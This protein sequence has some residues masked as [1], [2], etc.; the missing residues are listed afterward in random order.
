MTVIS[1]YAD[2]DGKTFYSDCAKRLEQNCK[3]LGLK[4][5]IRQKQYGS[6]WITNER[7]KPAFIKEMFD[8]IDDDLLWID[9]D[10]VIKR[11][12]VIDWIEC[13]IVWGVRLRKDGTPHDYVH[14]IANTEF[15]ASF[16]TS[17]INEIERCGKGSHTAFVNLYEMLD[18]FYLH[19]DFELVE[20][21]IPS[22]TTYLDMAFKRK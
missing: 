16:I 9:V 21:D 2:V 6:D 8:E 5:A 13:P 22:K 20:A 7:A 15:N 19:D 1:F 18:I 3:D 11:V 17:W 12:P 10:C 4:Y 14:Y